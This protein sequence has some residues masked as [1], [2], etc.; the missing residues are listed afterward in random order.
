MA[1]DLTLFQGN[2]FN[3]TTLIVIITFI[4]TV[5]R[6]LLQ[7]DEKKEE[8]NKQSKEVRAK[9]FDTVKK[10]LKNGT[11]NNFE[12]INNVFEGI[13]GK[14]DKPSSHGIHLSKWLKEFLVELVSIEK[15]ESIESETLHDWHQKIT[16]FINK[17]G[18]ASPY[19]E[20]SDIERNILIDISN[21]LENNDKENVNR[22]LSEL[23]GMIQ[24]RNDDL[25]KIRDTNK[26]A[27]S[28]AVAG[29][30]FT[31]IFGLVSILT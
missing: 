17:I 29:M 30:V 21:Y 10:G 19:S 27:I 2:I 26:W 6:F 14:F 13:V 15:E 18:E 31:I 22:K 16:G 11:I 1:V 20:L 23:A 9:F 3:V 5:I 12:D 8:E 4:T 24:T 28:L 25:N 7:L